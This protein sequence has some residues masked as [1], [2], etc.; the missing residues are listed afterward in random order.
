MGPARF[1]PPDWS[2]AFFLSLRTPDGQS[3]VGRRAV[4]GVPPLAGRSPQED[5]QR[6]PVSVVFALSRHLGLSRSDLAFRVT[7][8]AVPVRS[9]GAVPPLKVG[10]AEPIWFGT[11]SEEFWNHSGVML[12]PSAPGAI[13]CPGPRQRCRRRPPLRVPLVAPTRWPCS[14]ARPWRPCSR[15][16]MGSA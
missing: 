13:S 1:R 7:H 12:R 10:T 3:R 8:R 9:S 4:S 2:V 14:P 6:Q 5:A 15:T 11:G 16:C